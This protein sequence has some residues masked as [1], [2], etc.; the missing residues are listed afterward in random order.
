MFPAFFTSVKY[1]A[2]YLKNKVSNQLQSLLVQ[3]S[4]RVTPP[5]VHYLMYVL[6]WSVLQQSYHANIKIK[7][8]F[9][10]LPVK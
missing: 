6:F 1:D 8:L 7:L 10:I 9:N 3:L 4:W 2:F 5:L